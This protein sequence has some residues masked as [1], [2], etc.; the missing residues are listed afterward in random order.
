MQAAFFL[1]ENGSPQLCQPGILVGDKKRI[2][3]I[4]LRISLKLASK[5]L[6]LISKGFTSITCEACDWEGFPAPWATGMAIV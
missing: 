1:I 5:H 6:F 4:F 2:R 3:F